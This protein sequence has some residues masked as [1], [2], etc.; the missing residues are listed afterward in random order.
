MNDGREDMVSLMEREKDFL[1]ARAV[2][3]TRK[4]E[5]AEDL[6][7]D[8]L[9]KAYVGR[10]G[11]EPG[12]NFRA[13]IGRIMLN[14]QINNH[15]RKHDELA[16]DF[17]SGHMDNVIYDPAGADDASLTDNPEKVFFF[18]HV[19]RK[20]TEALYSIPESFRIP[21]SLY[22]FEGYAYEEI[23]DRLALPVGTIKSRIFRARRFL[24][25]RIR[26][27]RDRTL[28]LSA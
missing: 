4:R 3:L 1:W 2:G 17:S 8:T 22:H 26:G 24:R 11:F 14:T 19:D 16:G 12:T 15:N 23:A 20:I 18:S 28:A 21:F 6:L 9:M 5:D 10:D 13:W 27:G 25:D 7:Q